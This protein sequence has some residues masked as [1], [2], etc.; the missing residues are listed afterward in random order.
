[1]L[2]NRI[3]NIL[4]CLLT[5]AAVACAALAAWFL[6]ASRPFIGGVDFYYFILFARDL[7]TGLANAS[8]ARYAYFPGVYCFWRIVFMVSDGS[9]ESLQWANICVLIVNGALIGFILARLTR[10]WQAGLF[11]ATLYIFMASR[12]EGLC[13]V[14]EPIATIPYLLGLWLWIRLS[15]AAKIKSGLFALAAG[16]GLAL[17]M[18]QQ[19]G[20]LS[21]GT[22][23]LLPAMHRAPPSRERRLT[24]WLILPAGATAIFLAAMQL[25]GGGL[26]A[27][28]TGLLLI[29]NYQAAGT[30]VSH[31]NAIRE[32]TR[33]IS[34][35][36][37][38][39]C[40]AWIVMTVFRGN[41][42][43]VPEI[44]LST[45]GLCLF[46]VL[47]GLFQFSK[48]GYYHYAM[49]LLPSAIIVSGLSIF[50]VVAALNRR[51][52]RWPQYS[53]HA[54]VAGTI[55]FLLVNAAGTADFVHYVSGQLR[56]P[57]RWME[58]EELSRQ[59]APLCDRLQA[60][61]DLLLIP[62]RQDIV[63][64]FCRTHSDSPEIG[65]AWSA[66]DAGAYLAAAAYPASTNV[67]LFSEDSGKFEQGFFKDNP[68]DPVL[69]EL[70][71]L[72]YRKTFAIDAGQLFQ[73]SRP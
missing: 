32:I 1:M 17:F 37:L 56:A 26:A 51:F 28:K 11:A 67:F 35:F 72:G 41:N 19:A 24:Q 18:K 14:I 46:S 44:T 63:H 25:E 7:S 29:Q 15:D 22:L 2:R 39:A 20:L 61:S 5:A 45:F 27:V 31:L 43:P 60:G 33:P 54:M 66:D 55:L 65:Y 9:L 62:S 50:V 40:L 23:A 49:L 30:L 59:F 3:P 6:V 13:G 71:R 53:V 34:N 4:L 64:L 16:F 42:P 58:N 8:P 36:F 52:Q 69:L 21:L 57:T 70:E 12:V 47:G 10:A 38:S 68:R 48:R 73:R